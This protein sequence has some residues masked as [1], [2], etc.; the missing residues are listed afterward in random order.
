MD[1]RGLPLQLST[2][3]HL[4]QLLLTACLSSSQPVILGEH[5]VNRFI[6]D[7]P[8]LKSK[9]TQ[10]Y[11]YQHVKYKYPQLIKYWFTRVEEI[12]KRYGII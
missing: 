11:D 2:V 6:Q 5:W 10:K 9:Y 12:I 1:S 3:H 8:Q 4:A 7:H